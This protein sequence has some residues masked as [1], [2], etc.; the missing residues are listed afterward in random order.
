[1]QL[2]LCSPTDC[3]QLMHK[4]TC[5]SRTLMATVIPLA[6]P[7]LLLYKGSIHVFLALPHGGRM[8]REQNSGRK[9][10]QGRHTGLAEAGWVS[11]GHMAETRSAWHGVLLSPG[12]FPAETK[13][14]CGAS[15]S[16]LSCHL[17][18]SWI[19]AQVPQN[20]SSSASLALQDRSSTKKSRS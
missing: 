20:A 9:W 6:V 4:K 13:Q 10:C 7:V 19:A 1:M 3:C 18:R 12:S 11:V 16:Q 17:P 15:E 14:Q 8:G 2:C 5:W